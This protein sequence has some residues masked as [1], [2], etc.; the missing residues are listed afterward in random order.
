MENGM[1]ALQAILMLKP[2]LEYFWVFSNLVKIPQ[3]TL[4]SAPELKE[5]SIF[6]CLSAHLLDALLVEYLL[7]KMFSSSG[8]LLCTLFT[9]S[10]PSR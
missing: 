1:D 3:W 5:F 2:L 10:M 9:Y 8:F 6:P 4:L 7:L